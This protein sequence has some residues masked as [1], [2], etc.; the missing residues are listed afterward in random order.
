ML[1]KIFQK[2]FYN[3]YKFIKKNSNFIVFGDSYVSKNF[4]VRLA[5][6]KEVCLK[7]GN[8]CIL[9]CECIYE[10]DSG[11]ITIGNNVYI[12]GS[13]LISKELI[14][15]GNNV[16]ISWGVTLYD[17]NGYSLNYLDRQIELKKIFQNY[18]TGDMLKEFDWS[19]VK[20]APIIIE[21]DVWIGF[22]ATILK[23]VTIGKGSIVGAQSVVIKDVE[24]FT[25][26]M[27]N[28]AVKIKDLRQ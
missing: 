7:V 1:R 27:G 19:K 22:G 3:P 2:L 10:T 15:I 24:P 5:K 8:G 18:N 14:Q 21:N 28:P 23:G 11:S 16:Q 4:Q 25:I 17:H 26:V 12:G 9:E 20:S 6:P 13:K